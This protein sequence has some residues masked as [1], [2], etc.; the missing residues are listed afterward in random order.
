M[1]TL[2]SS[3]L[4]G[5]SSNLDK[6]GERNKIDATNIRR[7]ALRTMILHVDNMCQWAYM[8]Q[9]FDDLFK[10]VLWGNDMSNLCLVDTWN[11]EELL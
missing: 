3:Y 11:E 4:I 7:K 5:V 1:T 10:K 6:F 8:G 2:N 9:N